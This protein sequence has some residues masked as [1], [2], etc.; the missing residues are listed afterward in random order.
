MAV[1]GFASLAGVSSTGGALR[2]R[3]AVSGKVELFGRVVE[4]Y[5]VVGRWADRVGGQDELSRF[6]YDGW[7]GN[8]GGGVELW[9]C[10]S[11]W[12]SVSSSGGI[13][14]CGSL[15]GGY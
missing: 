4:V 8:W 2:K 7:L 10:H 15:R 11:T 3:T 6:A 1:R 13:M 5:V 12:R 14:V 9:W